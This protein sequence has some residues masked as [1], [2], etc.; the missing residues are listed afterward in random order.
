MFVIVSCAACQHP[1]RAELEAALRRRES[2]RQVARTY[3]LSPTNSTA[4][5]TGMF[6]RS[7][8]RAPNP[9]LLQAPV[10]ASTAAS[11]ILMAV[12]SG[13]APASIGRVRPSGNFL[14]EA[15]KRE[16][17]GGLTLRECSTVVVPRPPVTAPGRSTPVPWAQRLRDRTALRPLRTQP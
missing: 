4:T 2:F 11:S 3:R 13:A 7:P 8:E 16:H 9:R 1:Q 12:N 14:R 5:P 15:G 17:Q 10:G 6:P